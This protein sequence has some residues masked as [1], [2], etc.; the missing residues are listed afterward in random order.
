MKFCS[1]QMYDR[2]MPSEILQEA[3]KHQARVLL[4]E[5]LGGMTKG[6]WYAVRLTEEDFHELGGCGLV[7]NMILEFQPIPERRIH[8]V[9]AEDNFLV[10]TETK[11]IP[12]LKNCIAYLR[13]KTGGEYREERIWK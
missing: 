5:C 12:K 1:K 13:D 8:F 4:D 3:A 10:K 7:K 6:V 9:S 11:L 2:E